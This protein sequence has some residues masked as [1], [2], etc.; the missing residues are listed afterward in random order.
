MRGIRGVKLD[1][2][3]ILVTASAPSPEEVQTQP[4]TPDA[5]GSDRNSINFLLNCPEETDFLQEFP[6]SITLSP[7]SK[8]DDGYPAQMSVAKAYQPI[9][10]APP[11]P[12]YQEYGHMVQ[13][14]NIDV[15]LSNL[16]FQ[17]FETQTNNW[18]M[19]GENMML[20]SEP[21]ELLID[22]SILERKAYELRDKLRYTAVMQYP[23]HS[24]PVDILDAIELITADNIAVYIKL[25]FRHWHKHGPM[26]HEATFNPCTAAIP[27][28]LALM[29]LGGM[30]S[31]F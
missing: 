8:L 5:A 16:E 15:L 7:N 12:S 27:L 4:S 30:V 2:K 10:S 29:M 9:V 20:W 18:Q 11:V 31:T 22:R 24:P 21:G 25:Y 23:S 26:I 3:L 14:H 1:L 13:E 28:L 17:T 19:P 6:K